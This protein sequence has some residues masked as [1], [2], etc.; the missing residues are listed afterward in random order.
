MIFT[1]RAIACAIFMLSGISGVADAQQRVGP[2]ALKDYLA[3]IDSSDRNLLAEQLRKAGLFDGDPSKAEIQE[4]EVSVLQAYFVYLERGGDYH[5]MQH[6]Q[7][8]AVF[9]NMIEAGEID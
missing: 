4:L 6:W 1:A 9:V 8:I 7:S 5:D 2:D 3:S